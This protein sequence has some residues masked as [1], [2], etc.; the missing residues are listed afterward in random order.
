MKLAFDPNQPGLRGTDLGLR[1]LQRG[2]R[3]MALTSLKLPFTTIVPYTN[4]VPV[5][6]CSRLRTGVK[7]SGF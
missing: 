2:N 6:L 3:S 4:F 1:A 5:F 7:Q